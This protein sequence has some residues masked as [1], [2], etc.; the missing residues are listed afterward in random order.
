MNT[1]SSPVVRKLLWWK[2]WFP[3][4]LVLAGAV[5][6]YAYSS[7]GDYVLNRYVRYPGGHDSTFVGEDDAKV[8]FNPNGAY[9]FYK[10][11][12]VPEGSDPSTGISWKRVGVLTRLQH[13]D[14][15]WE[16]LGAPP[17]VHYEIGLDDPI[18][19]GPPPDRDPLEGNEGGDDSG[20]WWWGG[21]WSGESK[22]PQ[23]TCD[24]PSVETDHRAQSIAD[25]TPRSTLPVG[26]AQ[27]FLHPLLASLQLRDRPLSYQPA[28]GPRVDV[29]FSYD[30]LRV[31]RSEEA[32]ITNAGPKWRFNWTNYLMVE[33]GGTAVR[34]VSGAGGAPL[35]KQTG[36]QPST[37]TRS[38]RSFDKIVLLP[39]ASYELRK[40]NRS[41]EVYGPA[42]TLSSG[43]TIWPL[44]ER[45]DVSGNAVTLRWVDG[46][47]LTIT[48]AAGKR[49]SFSYL[50]EHP[51]RIWKISDPFGRV[52][53]YEY[54]AAGELWKVT[55]PIGII[56]EFRYGA[57][58][59]H[60]I[61]DLITPYGTS[62]F[63]CGSN[64]D[65][66]WVEA[67]GPTGAK[68]RVEYRL[69][70]STIEVSGGGASNSTTVVTGA[71]SYLWSKRAM[72]EYNAQD[73]NRYDY[74][75]RI[76]W[77]FANGTP[78][79][80]PQTV[81]MPLENEW[82]FTYQNQASAGQAG[83]SPL[84]TS[85]KRSLGNGT[86][87]EWKY[88]WTL[89]GKHQK[90]TDPLGRS[91]TYEYFSPGAEDLAA[92]IQTTGGIR[93]GIAG[94]DDYVNGQPSW[95]AG[96]DWR[97]KWIEYNARGQVK[98]VTNAKGEKARILYEENVASPAFGNVQSVIS[99]HGTLMAATRSLQYDQFG[100]V[101]VVTDVDGSTIELTYDAIGGDNTKSLDRVT[102]VI[103]PDATFERYDYD[104]LDLA[105]V[106]DRLGRKTHYEYDG[107]GRVSSVTDPGNHT[108]QLSQVTC[109][110]IVNQLLDANNVKTEW[111]YDVQNRV[112]EKK[113]AGQFVASYSYSDPAG[114]LSSITDA[115]GQV[116]TLTYTADDQIN[117]IA[118]N[119]AVTHDVSYTYNATYGWLETMTDATGVT[120]WTHHPAFNADGSAPLG[121]LNLAS[122]DGPLANDTIE[123]NYDALGRMAAQTIGGGSDSSVAYDALGRITLLNN[124]L[125]A[126]TPSYD[127]NTNRLASLSYPNGQ[128]VL[129]TYRPNAEDHRLATITNYGVP[130]AGQ[131]AVELSHFAY[132]YDVTGQIT[133]WLQR[134]PHINLGPLWN[135][136]ARIELIYDSIN[137]LTEAIHYD[138]DTDTI[139][140]ELFGYDVAGNRI[141][142]QKGS[143]VKTATPNFLNQISNVIAGGSMLVRGAVST[144][145]PVSI[146]GQAV[147]TDDN[148][149]FELRLPVQAGENTFTITATESNQ[150]SGLNP[151]TTSRVLHIAVPE[152]PARTLLYD[153]NGNMT[154]NGV[155][156][157][158][159]WD[160][161]NRLIAINYAMAVA[162]SGVTRS[163]FGYDGMDRRVRIVEKAGTVSVDDKR[164]LWNGIAIAQE[165]RSV[166][167]SAVKQFYPHGTMITSAVNPNNPQKHYFTQDHLGS[168]REMSDENGLLLARYD[169]ALWG[170][171]ER[172][173]GTLQAV[174]GFTGHYF[175]ETSGLHLALYRAYDSDVAIWLSRDPI[176]E[177]GGINLYTYVYNQ[178]SLLTDPLG[179]VVGGI[180][181]NFT[182]GF[183]GGFEISLS[184]LADDSFS[185]GA[186]ISLSGG[187]KVGLWGG[188]G[189]SPQ[190]SLSTA[191]TVCDTSGPSASA[192]L[193]VAV[194][195][196]SI[197]VG[198]GTDR[199]Y[200][201]EHPTLTGTATV[202]GP[203]LGGAVG[204]SSTLGGS[205]VWKFRNPFAH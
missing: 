167:E 20:D 66:R 165:T 88:E 137:Q 98:W 86:F 130:Q 172:V 2:R 142:T 145:G 90:V 75:Q 148:G 110:G 56:S 141:A 35:Y 38:D 184:V 186:A 112:T 185:R 1:T 154:N 21:G 44:H 120:T 183:L 24:V 150:P 11:S 203:G 39:N 51:K 60:F 158:Y 169:Y 139:T 79:G 77:L 115:K 59:D 123:S 196:G 182:A 71:E 108:I 93:E 174:F 168:I 74:A 22:T 95:V 104:K 28:F 170:R 6:A 155:G 17:I 4:V 89:S 195:G 116:K 48:D 157:T 64:Q 84:P 179:L 42:L 91:Q 202:T 194:G 122:V 127:G 187:F 131:P 87:Q 9:S 160:A 78:V 63:A 62:H 13:K 46:R 176:G 14:V 19:H 5:P 69:I 68:Q 166:S 80:I 191:E 198:R 83:S 156:Q 27:P 49:F 201:G 151:Q 55:D 147:S 200:G 23:A 26:M 25:A 61:D 31:A 140:T 81:K 143:D 43:E 10:A 50:P 136:E 125:G 193:D 180:G 8:Y 92:I 128:R 67:T 72:L 126:F 189:V 103:H 73:D 134:H 109:C 53:L 144:P 204:V 58:S 29:I 16:G 65:G 18:P 138:H 119:S 177:R 114:R 163:E 199:S 135:S 159:E 129:Y 162:P 133:N 33:Q 152:T 117:K 181:F 118:Y 178:P 102:K 96:P 161:E 40:P 146:A 97:P 124:P 111:Q 105:D 41:I 94:Y 76:G 171:R 188:F 164:L 121:A 34:L 82:V 54:N 15:L 7:P 192:N 100:R 85:R 205:A 52:A 132:A 106:Y 153:L 30:H 47:L 190:A 37:F 32:K 3:I 175:H 107:A 36:F 101:K 70:K 57:N 12:D 197:A 173:E 45:R 113:I 149:R 99:A